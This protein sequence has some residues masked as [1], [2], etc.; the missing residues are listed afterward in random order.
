MVIK[1]RRRINVNVLDVKEEKEVL[2]KVRILVINVLV[3]LM[4]CMWC[5]RWRINRL[6]YL[7]ILGEILEWKG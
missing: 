1:D 5:G 4:I 6:G 7:N 3:R 2:K